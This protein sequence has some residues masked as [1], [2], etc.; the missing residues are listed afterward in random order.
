MIVRI[1][2][3]LEL[4]FYPIVKVKTNLENE[5]KQKKAYFIF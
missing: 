2:C 1:F 3:D 5:D 4:Y